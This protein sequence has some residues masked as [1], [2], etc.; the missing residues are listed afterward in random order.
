M[1]EI[2]SKPKV[3]TTKVVQCRLCGGS[4]NQTKKTI[5]IFGGQTLKSNDVMIPI[6]EAINETIDLQ[7]N[8][9]DLFLGC[10]NNGTAFFLKLDNQHRR[11]STKS[12]V[13]A[14]L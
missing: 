4:F 7:V 13:Q 11:W 8:A 2:P 6:W 9:C 12:N 5:E 10:Q 1:S 3:D 14:V